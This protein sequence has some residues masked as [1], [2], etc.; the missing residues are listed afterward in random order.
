MTRVLINRWETSYWL[1]ATSH[2]TNSLLEPGQNPWTSWRRWS[3]I[4]MLTRWWLSGV[5]NRDSQYAGLGAGRLVVSSPI[6]GQIISNQIESIEMCQGSPPKPKWKN[7][8][9]CWNLILLTKSVIILN[10]AKISYSICILYRRWQHTTAITDNGL[11]LVAGIFFA[12]ITSDHM[13]THVT[14]RFASK[15]GTIQK[16]QLRSWEVKLHFHF[17][18]PELNI[19]QFRLKDWQSR[20]AN[21]KV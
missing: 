13:C 4:A 2:V 6:E 8:F 11:L 12:L 17:W 15:E 19:V 3:R 16:T 21:Y 1:A 18:H 10:I 7:F 14:E 5:S 20:I 9:S